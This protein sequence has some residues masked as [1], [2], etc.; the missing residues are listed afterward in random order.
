MNVWKVAK[1]ITQKKTDAGFSP[2]VRDEA[3]PRLFDRARSRSKRRL[4]NTNELIWHRERQYCNFFERKWM[5]KIPSVCAG[6]KRDENEDTVI[7]YT[8][9]CCHGALESQNTMYD[10]VEMCGRRL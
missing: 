5:I 4:A 2:S 9:T 1:K 8:D 3:Q 10:G 6:I 7:R